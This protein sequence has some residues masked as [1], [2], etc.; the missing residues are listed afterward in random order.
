MCRAVLRPGLLLALIAG[1]SGLAG[2]PHA[3]VAQA[4]EFALFGDNPYR[5]EGVPKVEALIEDVNQRGELRWVIHVGDTKGGGQPCSD[6]FLRSRFELY[7]NF[8]APFV[9]TPGDNDWYDCVR[10]SAGGWD[11]YERLDF[12]RGLY[13]PQ[14]GLTTGGRTME[15]RPQSSDPEYPEFVENVRWEHGGVVYAT[16]HLVGLTRAPEDGGASTRRV[17]AATAWI[18]RA[19]ETAREQGSAGVFIATQVDP[20]VVWGLPPLVRQICVPCLMPRPGLEPLYALLTDESSAF[21]G[22]VVLAV[23]DTHIFRVDKPLYRTDGSLV[24]NFT[25]VETF[26]DPLVHWVRVSVDPDTRSVFT[27]HQELVPGN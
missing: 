4:H 15:V 7:Q 17:E 21:P 25:R 12:L 13:F 19:F 1:A 8:A 5:P 11:A 9:F 22:Q 2:V 3:V 23:G 10:D 16:V 20:W 26:G 27:F 14:P 6:D 24:Q 18:A